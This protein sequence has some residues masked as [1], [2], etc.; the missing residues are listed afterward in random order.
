MKKVN[1][2]VLILTLFVGIFIGCDEEPIPPV[3]NEEPKPQEAP[4]LTQ[5]INSFIE[6]S[7][8][9]VYLWSN[10]LP[11]I[12]IRYEFDSKQ[13]FD[14]LLYQEDRWSFITEDME[15][16][17]NSWQGIEKSYGWSLTFG[18]F[19]NTNNIFALVEYVYPDTP[20]S[21]AGIK[22]GDIIVEIYDR[23][24]TDGNYRDLLNTENI[25]ITTGILG[26]DGISLGSSVSLTAR[27]LNLDP[28]LITEIIEHE[29]HKIG[30]IFYAQFIDNYLESIDNAVQHLMDNNVTDVVVDL[31]YN[32]GGY[33]FVAQHFCSA[34]GPMDAVEN[35]DVLITKKMNNYWTEYF[36]ENEPAYLQTNFSKEV[37]VKMGLDKIHVL[38]GSGTASA[39]EFFIVGLDPYMDVIKVGESTYGKYT[40]SWTIQPEDV[41]RNSSD[42][43]EFEKWGIQP[44]VLRYANSLGVTDFKEGILPDIE[45]YDELFEAVPLG[46]KEE[47]L[48]K[49]AI[50]NIT[51]TPILAMK[52]TKTIPPYTIFDRGF[53]KY[54]KYKNV[55][56]FKSEFKK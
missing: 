26:S 2:I 33:G 17:E 25:K 49:A 54:D 47:P 42:Y 28:I 12:D 29:G 30:Y 38:T 46:Q 13:Y 15:E 36:L 40:G 20:A 14:K 51:G 16:Y 41:F 9:D 11:D 50:E 6:F 7:M 37:P 10:E 52:S 18:R 55:V 32:P 21:E 8:N 22:R 4:E 27:D 56:N 31:R 48:L 3:N 39:S 44:I 35:E 1:Y 19:S 45:V 43:Q 23:D 24:I 5:S 34:V 53:S